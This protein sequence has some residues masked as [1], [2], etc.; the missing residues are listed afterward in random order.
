MLVFSYGN[1]SYAEI[2]ANLGVFA[3]LTS[4]ND[5]MERTND[6]ILKGKIDHPKMAR[7]KKFI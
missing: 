2:F 3:K 1:T 7:K 4:I 5:W 6:S